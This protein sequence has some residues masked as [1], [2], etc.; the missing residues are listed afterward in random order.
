[1]ILNIKAEISTI[2]GTV[3]LPELPVNKGPDVAASVLTAIGTVPLV[4]SVYNVPDTVTIPP[5]AKV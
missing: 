5:G 4:E 2:Q 1:M 3:C